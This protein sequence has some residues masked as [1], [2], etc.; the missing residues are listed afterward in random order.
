MI[1]IEETSPS[2][3]VLPLDAFKAHLRLGTGFA[4]DGLQDSV[5][6]GF[7]RAAIAAVEARTGKALLERP[8]RWTLSYWRD[9]AAQPLPIAPI[10]ELLSV[11]LLDAGGDEIGVGLDELRLELDSQTPRLRSLAGRL[12]Q[13]PTNGSVAV[14]F[15]A[16]FGAEWGALPADLAQAVLLLAAHY[17]EYRS[18]TSLGAGCMP[19]GVTSLIQ[20]YRPM[21]L[22]FGGQL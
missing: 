22:S 7:L 11:T 10:G 14:R 12:P 4:E 2:D 21:R 17:Y 5:L 20:R 13:I 1:L 16:G 18:E 6:Q 19:F 8:F 15:V 3:A 9:A